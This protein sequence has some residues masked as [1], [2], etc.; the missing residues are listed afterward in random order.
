M[1]FLVKNQMSLW[2]LF[3]RFIFSPFFTD[4]FRIRKQWCAFVSA[5]EW[6]LRRDHI[7]ENNSLRQIE[8]FCGRL[9]CLTLPNAMD[10][11]DSPHL[12]IPMLRTWVEI[13]CVLN[14]PH[15]RSRATSVLSTATIPVP[16]KFLPSLHESRSD[17]GLPITDQ[18]WIWIDPS[19]WSLWTMEAVEPHK[20]FISLFW[21]RPAHNYIYI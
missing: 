1:V 18:W 15:S 21:L 2:R 10:G 20:I 19:L 11:Y 17:C 16:A 4:L 5:I 12:L 8:S 6:K 13:S 3:N 14:W 9:L 7:S